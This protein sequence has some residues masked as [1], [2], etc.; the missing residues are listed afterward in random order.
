MGMSLSD[1]IMLRPNAVRGHRDSGY[2]SMSSRQNTG[3]FA[4]GAGAVPITAVPQ[5]IHEQRN[6][7]VVQR[8]KGLIQLSANSRYPGLILQPDS[9]PIS[10]EQLGAEVKGIYAGLVMVE[11]KCVNIDAAQAADPNSQLGPEQWQALIALHRTLLYEHHDF[12]MATQHPSATQALRGLPTKYSIPARMWKHGIHTFLEVLRHRRPHSQDYML[13]FIYLAYQMMALL[14]ETVPSFTDT[15]IECLGDLAR[16]RMAIEE[17]KEAHATWG[18]VA[19]RWYT[20]A[21]DRHP[22]IGRLYHHLGILERPSLRK[23]CLYAKSLS[24]VIPFPN[25]R[26]SLS[27]LCGP[28]VQDENTIQSSSHSVE[29]RIVTYHA[30][31][32]SKADQ[33]VIDTIGNDALQLLHQQ[34]TKLRDIGAYLAVTNIAAIFELGSPTNILFQQY[35]TAINRAMQNSRPSTNPSALADKNQFQPALS[36]A[37]PTPSLVSTTS[38]WEN[39][40][41]LALKNYTS[42]EHILPYVHVMLVSLHSLDSLRTRHSNDQTQNHTVDGFINTGRLAWDLLADF[43][44]T[45]AQSQPISAWILECARQRAFPAPERKE[46][47]KP[48]SEDFLIR[49]LIWAQ[50][51]F[52]PGWFDSQTEDDGR[53]IESEN[54]HKARVER[55]LWLGLY[56]A[57]HTEP[58]HYDVQRK[59][60]SAP[61]YVPPPPTAPLDPAEVEMAECY[62]EQTSDAPS[63]RS[64]SSLATSSSPSSEDGFTFVKLPKPTQATS[65]SWANVAAKPTTKTARKQRPDVNTFKVADPNGMVWDGE[66]EES[67]GY[68]SAHGIRTGYSQ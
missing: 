54:T 45:L 12:L 11:A 47:V 30:L 41:S 13:A 23:F 48:L 43:L 6:D 29:A 28:I 17:E 5:T 4:S 9:S 65:N 25:A 53:S 3:Q 8:R 52:A 66:S 51:Y 10:Q 40:F 32:Y 36:N 44:N 37:S 16:Y 33:K 60:F 24:C 34:L 20:M 35:A 1:A 55:V 42:I 7:D 15:W 19:A 56:L 59:V 68:R 39:T 58:L 49:G 61:N 22:A 18:G 63:P 2:D 14:L 64:R 67:V 26:D 27:T 46:D 31:V 21:S 38:F 62:T 50:F 57:F